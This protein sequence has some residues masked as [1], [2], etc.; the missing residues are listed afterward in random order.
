[1]TEHINLADAPLT[2]EFLKI[3][4]PKGSVFCDHT[5]CDKYWLLLYRHE[6]KFIP[7]IIDLENK[8]YHRIVNINE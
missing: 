6:N 1:M 2:K 5:C 4:L 7:I 3:D 8:T